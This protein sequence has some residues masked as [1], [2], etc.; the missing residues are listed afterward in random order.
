MEFTVLGDTVNTAARLESFDLGSSASIDVPCR[1]LIG[2]STRALVQELFELEFLGSFRVKGK[3]EPIAIYRVV[4]E[5]GRLNQSHSVEG[6]PSFPLNEG[7][8]ATRITNRV[9]L[10]LGLAMVLLGLGFV[11]MAAG[12]TR[13]PA[14]T[15]PMQTQ[16]ES[17]ETRS[18]SPAPR[19]GN[20][21]QPSRFPV[22]RKAVRSDTPMQGATNRALRTTPLSGLRWM[23]SSNSPAS[24]VT[25]P[26]YQPPRRGAPKVRIHAGSRA[27]SVDAA[28][29]LVAFAPEHVGLT[30]NARPTLYWYLSK[31]TDN[32]L[33]FALVTEEN[34][35]PVIEI[36]FR[37]DRLGMWGIEL[38]KHGIELRP[39]VLYRWSIAVV[40]DPKRRSKD[41]VAGGM[42]ERVADELDLSRNSLAEDPMAFMG[43]L[44]RAGIW[45]DLID[46][47]IGRACRTGDP[48]PWIRVLNALLR[49]VNLQPVNPHDLLLRR[50]NEAVVTF[51]S[52]STE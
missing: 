39:G 50:R 31:A 52:E 8:G 6:S 45:Y 29:V 15:E 47:I 33:E 17:P 11:P 5:R 2:E 20:S 44:A 51:I 37:P 12:Q 27:A 28:S 49:Q 30:R 14:R 24:S 40:V 21:P 23:E 25:I 26:I 19:P 41:W 42:I 34:P 7:G 35:D 3:A 1:I 4:S 13:M 9:G 18:L 36:V 43:E 22:L 10:W 32:D 38:G 48:D 46:E 16:N